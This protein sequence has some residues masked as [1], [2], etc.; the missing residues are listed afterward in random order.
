MANLVSRIPDHLL[1]CGLATQDYGKSVI[2]QLQSNFKSP[3]HYLVKYGNSN[4]KCQ[5]SL[6]HN[7]QIINNQSGA[8]AHKYTLIYTVNYD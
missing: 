8:H 7:L 4:N 1:G 2:K 3:G 6:V 5:N